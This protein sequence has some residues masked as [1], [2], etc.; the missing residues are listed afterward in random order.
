M[1]VQHPIQKNLKI[2]KHPPEENS[3][4]ACGD[5]GLKMHAKNLCN[6]CY[7]G[8]KRQCKKWKA[9][10]EL[11]VLTSRS[12]AEGA[13]D[14]GRKLYGNNPF[15]NR[16]GERNFAWK[17]HAVIL[18]QNTIMVIHHIDK[19]RNNN[20]PSNL[21]PLCAKCHKQHHCDEKK[22]QQKLSTASFDTVTS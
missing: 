10:N 16:C 5:I 14:I 17:V 3:C 6:S 8:W 13:R 20:Q 22:Q 18:C 2:V 15:C 4:R 7:A 1:I 9:R 11:V 12:K 19:D 21:E